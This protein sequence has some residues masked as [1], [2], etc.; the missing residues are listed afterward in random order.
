MSEGVELQVAWSSVAANG[1]RSAEVFDDLVGRHRQPHR[2]Y[3]SLRHVV[4]VLR[5]SRRL[6]E[7]IVECATDRYDAAAVTATAFFHDAIYDPRADDNEDRSATLAANQLATLGWEAARCAM[8]GELVR[9]TAGHLDG[10]DTDGGLVGDDGQD[11]RDD[12]ADDQRVPAALERAV[13]LDADLAVL[14]AEPAAYADYANGVRMEYA[15]LSALQWAAGRGEVL[16][17][18]LDRPRL[19]AT[20]PGRSWWDGNARANLNAELAGLGLRH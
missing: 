15:H 11:G 12:G 6:E 4:W 13:L 20:A 9:A 7:A 1:T 19:F 3:H 8:V 5:H 10:G 17:R 2:H 14:G 16:R 18:L